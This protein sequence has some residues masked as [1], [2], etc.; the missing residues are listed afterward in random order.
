MEGT[1]GCWSPG[2]LEHSER[3]SRGGVEVAG[4]LQKVRQDR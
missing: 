1:S 3:F 2:Y 4:V